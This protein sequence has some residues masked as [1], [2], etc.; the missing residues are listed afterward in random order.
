MYVHICQSLC[1]CWW[2]GICAGRAS[3]DGRLH[4]HLSPDNIWIT[5]HGCIGGWK[6]KQTFGLR[7]CIQLEPGK[8]HGVAKGEGGSIFENLV[9]IV[10][11]VF[12]GILFFLF[13]S[14]NYLISFRASQLW[15]AGQIG[16]KF[17]SNPVQIIH[18]SSPSVHLCQHYMFKNLLKQNDNK[19]LISGHH[20]VSVLNFIFMSR[21]NI[22]VKR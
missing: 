11:W 21:M 18:P 17:P 19:E 10:V 6:N 9:S 1:G 2:C 15:G 5:D 22:C 14:P 3:P 4:F 12:S 13:Y 8:C 7:I 16:D 20:S